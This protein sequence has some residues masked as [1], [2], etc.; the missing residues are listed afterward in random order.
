M[1][2]ATH[3]C[4]RIP[5]LIHT[6]VH[7]THTHTHPYTS[8]LADEELCI[9]AYICIHTP[10]NHTHTSAHTRTHTH[11]HRHILSCSLTHIH[12]YSLYHTHTHT[13]IDRER[14]TAHYR[15]TSLYTTLFSVYYTV[16]L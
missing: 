2:L 8:T 14:H 7:S 3:Y 15:H 11:T 13:H 12:I 10:P 16:S 5:Q 6:Y 4:C 1:A 9:N